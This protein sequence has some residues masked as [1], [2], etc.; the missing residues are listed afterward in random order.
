MN[1]SLMTR[2]RRR[3]ISDAAAGCGRITVALYACVDRPALS[4]TTVLR[5]LGHY[6]QARDWTVPPEAIAY[7]TCPLDTPRD[8]RP[9]WP[10]LEQLIRERRISGLLVPSEEHMTGPGGRQTAWR[11]WLGRHGVFIVCLPESLRQEVGA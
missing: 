8:A 5:Y 4:P 7:D 6:A 11:D 2:E 3:N 10:V 1:R 9:A